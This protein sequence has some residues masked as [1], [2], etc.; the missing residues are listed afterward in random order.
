[1]LITELNL[2]L[3]TS[4]FFIMAFVRSTFVFLFVL[5]TG[6]SGNVAADDEVPVIVGRNNDIL[7]KAKEDVKIAENTLRRK[8]DILDKLLSSVQQKRLFSIEAR[9]G[10]SAE[11]QLK[12]KEEIDRLHSLQRSGAEELFKKA[13]Q[14]KVKLDDEIYR[15]KNSQTT[16]INNAGAGG[17]VSRV[18][19]I[20]RKQYGPPPRL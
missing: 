4:H 3:L 18:Y 14:K 11:R 15:M 8:R 16:W 17:R 20:L 12:L 2:H 5:I 7:S 1:M 19:N 10:E 9:A 6:L 13:S